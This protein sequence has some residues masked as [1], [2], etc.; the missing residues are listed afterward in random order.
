MADGIA[1]LMTSIGIYLKSPCPLGASPVG[2]VLTVVVF[3]SYKVAIAF[4]GRPS[5]DSVAAAETGL[6]SGSPC[7]PAACPNA[8]RS[9]SRS[10]ESGAN[11]ASTSD[12]APPPAP[13]T[14]P[15]PP[16]PPP[17]RPPDG[18]PRP[19]TTCLHANPCPSINQ[20]AT[21]RT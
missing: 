19:P 8:D 13:P 3:I 20:P 6:I 14:P 16:P 4:E 2:L 11:A 15:P 18:R 10:I 5:D 7:F 21:W 9:R 17:P 1:A 12:D